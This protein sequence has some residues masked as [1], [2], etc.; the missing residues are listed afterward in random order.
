MFFTLLVDY[1]RWHYGEALVH[2]LRILKTWWWFVLAYFS[3]PLLLVTL[4]APFKR[5]YEPHARGERIGVHIEHIV[6]NTLSRLIGACIRLSLIIVALFLLVSLTVLGVFGYAIW[7]IAPGIPAFLTGA[8][9][10]LLVSSLL[11]V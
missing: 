4:F 8:G 11:G 6:I 2:Y 1:V 7:L 10:F 5:S 9:I 3:V